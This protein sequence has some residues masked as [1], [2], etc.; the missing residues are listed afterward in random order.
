MRTK[1]KRETNHTKT[2]EGIRKQTTKTK[3][4][5]TQTQTQTRRRRSSTSVGSPVGE[6][7]DTPTGIITKE[8]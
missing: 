2:Q 8:N 6:N 4:K 7:K 1:T 3:T 5:T